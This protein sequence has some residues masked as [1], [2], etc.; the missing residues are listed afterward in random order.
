MMS[1]EILN[2]RIAKH[3]RRGGINDPKFRTYEIPVITISDSS[4]D[5]Y[6]IYLIEINNIMCY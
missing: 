4:S 2:D 1:S 3:R 6:S 5:G